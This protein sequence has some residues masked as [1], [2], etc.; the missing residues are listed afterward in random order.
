MWLLMAN[1]EN[2]AR[3]AHRWPGQCPD[4]AASRRDA[5]AS[6]DQEL[7]FSLIVEAWRK[8]MTLRTFAASILDRAGH[9]ANRIDFALPRRSSG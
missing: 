6:R 8:T 2:E 7:Q 5:G 9:I 3:P 1:G 4:Q